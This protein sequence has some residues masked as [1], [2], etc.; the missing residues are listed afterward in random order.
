MD[1]CT[2]VPLIPLSVKRTSCLA[3]YLTVKH[4]PAFRHVCT[5][6]GESHQRQGCDGLSGTGFSD[7]AHDL[8][9]SDLNTD[10]FYYLCAIKGHRKILYFYHRCDLLIHPADSFP[11]Q[12]K[13]KYHPHN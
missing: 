10:V 4:N 11:E 7:H 12:G 1:I 13:S 3:K 2:P 5:F 9:L 6:R 8:S